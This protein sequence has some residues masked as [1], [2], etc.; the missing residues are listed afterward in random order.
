AEAAPGVSLIAELGRSV[1]FV[2]EQEVL[3]HGDIDQK[4]LIASQDGLVL[5]DWDLVVPVVPRRELADVA[6]S[7][8]CWHDVGIAHM[9]VDSYR[10]AGGEVPGFE[11]P[12]IGQSLAS[13]L[14]WIA[15][16][17]ERPIGLRP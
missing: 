12:D 5:C 8:A 11:P 16:N 1:T 7:L 4:N 9:L 10:D 17:V 15:F 14:D 2:P 13:G 6:L 3:S